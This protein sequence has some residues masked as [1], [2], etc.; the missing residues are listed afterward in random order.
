MVDCG[1]RL[2]LGPIHLDTGGIS[3][4]PVALGLGILL[5][6][7]LILWAA[8]TGEDRPR[9]LGGPVPV[10]HP[11]LPDSATWSRSSVS[12]GEFGILFIPPLWITVRAWHRPA[13][14]RR[15][16]GQPRRRG[17]WHRRGSPTGVGD[18]GPTQVVRLGMAL[19]IVGIVAIGLTLSVDRSPWWLVIPLIVYGLG[20]GLHRRS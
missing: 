12:L 4:V 2:L 20:L 9:A 6:A 16:P 18:A 1:R 7:A 8:A 15:D 11:A 17:R 19:E 3:V 14:H 5:L 13:D 10:R